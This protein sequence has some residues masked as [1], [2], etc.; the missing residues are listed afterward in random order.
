MQHSGFMCTRI[1][2]KSVLSTSPLPRSDGWKYVVAQDSEQDGYLHVWKQTQHL[3]FKIFNHRS[4]FALLRTIEA[5]Q[6][7]ALYYSHAV[8]RMPFTVTQKIDVSLVLQ[9]LHL[10]THV[11]VEHLK[12]LLQ[13][14]CLNNV[15]FIVPTQ[16]E[17]P[18]E[19][20]FRSKERYSRAQPQ[21]SPRLNFP[22]VN[23]LSVDLTGKVPKSAAITN[24]DYCAICVTDFKFIFT[25]GLVKKS[26]APER[27]VALIA[28]FP[29]P[30]KKLKTDLGP[31]F[32]STNFQKWLRFN[33][34][35]HETS[36]PQAHT[37]NGQVERL[38]GVV[39][40]KRML[41]LCLRM[42]MHLKSSGT[43]RCNR[44]VSS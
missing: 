23:T 29:A 9:R 3:Y 15:H 37:D 39:T 24:Y 21:S 5:N 16:V 31:E 18:C 6:A 8:R 14:N 7:Q 44:P 32:M 34:I 27:L 10:S 20:C 38:V 43:L 1:W 33:N 28:S 25:I 40:S 11:P 12:H 26:E 2:F 41:E 22:V 17:L 4:G 30:I 13:H 42:P 35:Q 19:A 36:L